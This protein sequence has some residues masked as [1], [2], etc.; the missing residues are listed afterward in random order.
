MKLATRFLALAVIVSVVVPGAA[1][2]ALTTSHLATDDALFALLPAFDF[3]AE[4]RIGDLGGAATF[5]LDLGATTS[6]P[7]VGASSASRRLTAR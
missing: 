3:V 7:S 1:V 5:E 2:A 4:G 6:A